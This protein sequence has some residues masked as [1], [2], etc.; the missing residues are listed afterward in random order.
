M[1]YRG[2]M[3]CFEG[4]REHVGASMHS[5]FHLGQ[6]VV[7]SCPCV[8]VSFWPGCVGASTRSRLRSLK[9]LV[10]PL[11]SVSRRTQGHTGSPANRG[12]TANEENQMVT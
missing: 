3:S 4:G 5:R 11:F 8:L 6:W 9:I 1:N 7:S 10:V 2:A 12:R